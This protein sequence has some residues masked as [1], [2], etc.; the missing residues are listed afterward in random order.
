[1]RQ[2]SIP[3]SYLYGTHNQQPKEHSPHE[4]NPVH[5]I[6]RVLTIGNLSCDELQRLVQQHYRDGELHYSDPFFGSQWSHLEHRLQTHNT[7]K[8]ISKLWSLPLLAITL[9]R[10][11]YRQNVDVQDDE[12]E[13]ERKSHGANQPHVGP[14]GHS[15]QGLVLRQTIQNIVNES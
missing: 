1:M 12:V 6:N 7:Q 3:L 15:Q 10:F 11:T 8:C 9:F 14:W 2:S 5:G 4:D 13:C